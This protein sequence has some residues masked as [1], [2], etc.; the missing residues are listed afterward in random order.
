MRIVNGLRHIFNRIVRQ[1]NYFRNGLR[2]GLVFVRVRWFRIPQKM[3]IAGK[4]VPLC[5]PPEH[6]VFVDFLVCFLRNEYGL[7]ERLSSVKTILD[8]GANLGFF[9][10]AARSFYPHATIHSYEPNPRVLPFLNAN[11]R[12]LEIS[13]FPEAVGGTS[14]R[15][16]MHDS[17]DSNLARSVV[18]SDGSIPQVSLATA[19]ERLG[20]TVDLLK[21]DCEGAEW[22]MFGIAEPWRHIRNIRMEYHLFH[23]QTAQDVERNLNRL[24]FEVIHRQ[25]DLRFGSVWASRTK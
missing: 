23:D 22:E 14:G 25:P 16:S 12:E 24:G 15:V 20:G 3:R 11:L 10:M 2:F 1:V 21:L 9:S 4:S 8:I 7:Q 18:D 19:I 6:G 13:V 5:L 17:G